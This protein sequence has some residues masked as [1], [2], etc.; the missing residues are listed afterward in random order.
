MANSTESQAIGIYEAATKLW[1]EGKAEDAVRLL[2]IALELSPNL[3]EARIA[4]SHALTTTGD[5]DAA[6]K[7]AEH[8]V[9]LRGDCADAKDALFVAYA[10]RANMHSENQNWRGAFDSIQKAV[11]SYPEHQEAA[12]C[13]KS[14]WF[15]AEAANRTEEF[16]SAGR[17]FL[18]WNP[19]CNDIRYR[20]GRTLAKLKRFEEAL[21]FLRE[22]SRRD[23]GN[24]DGHLWLSLACLAAHRTSE[25]FEEYEVLQ[26][27]SPDKAKEV[28]LVFKTAS[29]FAPDGLQPSRS[30]FLERFFE[31]N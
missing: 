2:L 31:S 15:M 9:R 24:V 18:G 3:V 21:P 26:A 13:L 17:A 6:I 27:L 4:A 14:M 29:V 12:D 5:H 1:F 19:E 11:F 10:G 8:A 28:S 7:H 23:E 30:Q 22:Y 16:L 25:A 20:L